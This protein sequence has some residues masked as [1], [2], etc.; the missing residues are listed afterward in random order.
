MSVPCSLVFSET[1]AL[2]AFNWLRENYTGR[3][4]L[5]H[6]GFPTPFPTR[7]ADS[8]QSVGGG[9]PTSVHQKPDFMVHVCTLLNAL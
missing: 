9:D 6:V 1:D 3:I 4:A 5:V 2:C 8:T 7:S